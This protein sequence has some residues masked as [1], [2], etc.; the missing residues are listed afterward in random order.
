M[1]KSIILT[2]LFLG[3]YIVSMGM[4][5]PTIGMPSAAD[6]MNTNDTIPIE[7]LQQG[8]KKVD[9][10]SFGNGTGG[11]VEVWS[12][13]KYNKEEKGTFKTQTATVNKQTNSITGIDTN[14]QV[15]LHPGGTEDSLLIWQ[16]DTV[17]FSIDS[18]LSTSNPSA[19]M[20]CK[21]GAKSGGFRHVGGML[22]LK[23]DC[24]IPTGSKR[25]VIEADSATIISGAFYVVLGKPEFEMKPLWG[26]SATS[27][28]ITSSTEKVFIPLPCNKYKTLRVAFEDANGKDLAVSLIKD[29]EIKRAN[30]TTVTLKEFDSDLECSK[31]HLDRMILSQRGRVINEDAL[32]HY[33]E[34]FTK[35]PTPLS[36]HTVFE[37]INGFMHNSVNVLHYLRYGQWQPQIHTRHLDFKYRDQPSNPYWDFPAELELSPGENRFHPHAIVYRQC[38]NSPRSS[39]YVS[40]RYETVWLYI[41]TYTCDFDYKYFTQNDTLC[42]Y[43]PDWDLKWGDESESYID[44]EFKVDGDE[45][46]KVTNRIKDRKAHKKDNH[47]KHELNMGGSKGIHFWAIATD[48]IED[49]LI[50][51]HGTVRYQ[52]VTVYRK[53]NGNVKYREAT[54][55]PH[56]FTTDIIG[57]DET[58]Q[59]QVNGDLE[60]K[61][62]FKTAFVRSFGDSIQFYPE[63]FD[64]MER[65]FI[66][67]TEDE[68]KKANGKPSN[69]KSNKHI[70]P[71][72]SGEEFKCVVSGL[73]PKKKYYVWAYLQI[74]D[75]QTEDYLFLS[76]PVI[77]PQGDGIF[78]DLPSLW[79]GYIGTLYPYAEDYINKYRHIKTGAD[80]GNMQD[81][82]KALMQKYKEVED[83]CDAKTKLLA[84][85]GVN[86]PIPFTMEEGLPFTI[87]EPIKCE[88]ET[89][90]SLF[91]DISLYEGSIVKVK[92]TP[93]NYSFAFD[94][95]SVIKQ[96]PLVYLAGAKLKIKLLSLDFDPVMVLGRPLGDFY[97]FYAEIPG[98]GPLGMS[99]VGFAQSELIDM[100]GKK[101][102]DV[103]EVKFF[104]LGWG[105]KEVVDQMKSI[106]FVKKDPYK[107]FKPEDK[108]TSGRLGDFPIDP[109][110]DWMDEWYETIKK[111]KGL[112]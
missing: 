27:V 95:A 32:H 70:S 112:K 43:V 85:N 104:I 42:G 69:I 78:A 62:F 11:I 100:K 15:L 44:W 40:G 33:F 35:D 82:E 37:G 83:I 39:K 30:I 1:R 55:D 108:I 4:V 17:F 41:K 38:G 71:S 81:A 22:Q 18:K 2:F 36:G 12:T 21:P 93:L 54:S 6:R 57:I 84:T 63:Y 66:I 46:S 92:T 102:G 60:F 90:P 88:I 14:G 25:I 65:G 79:D 59:R 68:Y 74:K 61:G 28:S 29:V 7:S 45:N 48:R 19:I 107:A 87:V 58:V 47:L 97:R 75:R 53:T 9:Y 56:K 99:H 49:Y 91:E 101:P 26:S 89:P 5:L 77:Y 110:I 23:F 72:K 51:K 20:L 96:Y 16:N 34:V 98:N 50:V 67:V 86:G 80:Y 10:P 103:I 24:N 8:G 3:S 52:A 94:A 64:G 31:V 109:Y 111:K 73:D 106:K 105:P 13:G 76:D